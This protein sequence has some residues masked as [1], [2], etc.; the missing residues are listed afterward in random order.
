MKGVLLAA[1]YGTRFLPVTRC[2]PKEMLPLL[3]RPAIDFVFQE[4]LQAGVDEILV[5]TSRRKRA[6]E[7][8]FDRDPELEAV[9]RSEQDWRKLALA[10][11][12]QAEVHFRRQRQMRG[13][14][15]AILLAK[16]F[17]GDEPFVVVFPDDIFG[18]PNCIE[19]LIHTFEATGRMVLAARDLTGQ[20]V[21]RYGV[22]DVEQDGDHLRL[23]RIVE[24]PLPGEE[25]SHL[26]SLGRYLYTSEIFPLLEAGLAAQRSGEYY[27]MDAI[28]RLA[29]R[30]RIAARVLDAPHYDTGTPLGYLKTVVASSLAHPEVGA[31]FRAWLI[32]QLLTDTD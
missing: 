22:L 31:P 4:M 2:I 20:D 30:G 8:W 6:L 3:D 14:G 28:N 11:P 24:K 25:P 29:R 13:T 23:R 16:D 10:H 9:F 5:I 12:P 17:V 15:H 7:D 1:G 19:Q 26:V 21:S 18:A 32:E 27:P